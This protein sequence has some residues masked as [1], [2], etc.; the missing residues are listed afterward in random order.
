M[1]QSTHSISLQGLW[2]SLLSAVSGNPT[3]GLIKQGPNGKLRYSTSA[4]QLYATQVLTY[5]G[6]HFPQEAETYPS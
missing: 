5:P 3:D 2:A 4:A 6:F 1:Q